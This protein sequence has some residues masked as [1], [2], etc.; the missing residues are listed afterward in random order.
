MSIFAVNQFKP[1]YANQPPL[2]LYVV[3]FFFQLNL[4]S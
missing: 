4:S 3:V 1:D 2:S